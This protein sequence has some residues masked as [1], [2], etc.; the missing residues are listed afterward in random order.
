MLFPAL[1][2]PSNRAAM[3]RAFFAFLRKQPPWIQGGDRH[4]HGD[5]IRGDEPPVFVSLIE[6]ELRT[7]VAT[8]G[9]H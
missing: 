5:V 3:W 6:R 1:F 8:Y 9:K 4:S 7:I 2:V